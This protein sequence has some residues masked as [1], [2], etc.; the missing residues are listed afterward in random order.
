[1]ANM[2]TGFK[3]S[4][5]SSKHVVNVSIIT[6]TLLKYTYDA[7]IAVIEFEKGSKP[8]GC[9]VTIRGLWKLAIDRVS[10]WEGPGN[11]WEC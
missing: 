4:I 1:M 7:R 6:N 2:H 8:R 10:F 3:T 5:K 11:D 9:Y